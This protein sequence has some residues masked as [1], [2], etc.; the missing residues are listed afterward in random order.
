MEKNLRECKGINPTTLNVLEEQEILSLRS[1][2]ALKEE[3]FCRML[4]RRLL[5]IGQHAL[6][7]EVWD[8]G[9]TGQSILFF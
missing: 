4:K 6:L 5:S 3:H 8:E 7:W 9:V 2:Y 1:F